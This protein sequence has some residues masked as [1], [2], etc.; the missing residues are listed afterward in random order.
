MRI[1]CGH[2]TEQQVE[3]TI[4]VYGWVHRIR[5]H[6]GVLFIDCR[7]ITGVIQIVCNPEEAA[8]FAVAQQLRD[9]YV[10]E[11]TGRIRPRPAGTDNATLTTGR[12][13]MVA[14]AINILNPSAPLPFSLNAFIPVGENTRFTY[15]YLD[16]RRPEIADKIKQRARGVAILRQYLEA[17][18]FLDIETPILTKT[19]PEGARDYLVPS[20]VHNGEFYA[21][22]Q[23]PQIFKQILM[24][25]GFDRY[26]Q[27]AR[28]FR[29]E[30]LRADRQPEFSQLDIEMSFVKQQDVMDLAE[31]AVVALFKELL[32]V[33]LGSF[34]VMR[35]QDAMQQYGSDKPDLRNP[36][37][38]TPCDDLLTHSE[39]AV[40]ADPANKKGHRVAA[41][42]LPQGCERLSRKDIDTYTNLVMQFGAKGL[43]YIKVNDIDAGMEGMQSPLLKF[44][45][46]DI[47]QR[48][49]QR[50]GAENGDILFFGAGS[51]SVVNQTMDILRQQLGKDLS[52]LTDSWKPLW[53][54]D[55][56]MFEAERDDRGYLSPLHH[57]FTAP[58]QPTIEALE[59]KPLEALSQAYDLVLNGYEVGGGSIRI[60][61]IDLQM[62]ILEQIGFTEAEAQGKFGHLLQA[63]RYGCPPHGGIAL[64]L[65]RLFML[66]TGGDSIRDVIAFP[67]TQSASCLLTDAPSKADKQQLSELGIRLRELVTEKKTS[68]N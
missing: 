18:H 26:Y 40:F 2:I 14:S 58:K 17:E 28:C 56:P 30:D 49:I 27:V 9:E 42:R 29:D 20:R 37:V 46:W 57:Q 68:A 25:A 54:V 59:E 24:I 34:P 43:A 64:G 31:G 48:I 15:R 33:D 41:L 61:N 3:Q 45:T 67:K 32:N 19:T 7:D 47:V 38:L 63:L 12:Y 23:S 10:V 21:L 5:D 44:L 8:S 22:P 4:S 66:M 51:D 53:V 13:E 35:Y 65:D 55:F 62:Y 36:L 50:A 60:D 52:L 39:F 6:G 16:L 1:Y 11:V